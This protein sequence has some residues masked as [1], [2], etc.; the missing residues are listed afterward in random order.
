MKSKAFIVAVLVIGGSWLAVQLIQIHFR[1]RTMN[2]RHK[3]ISFT[4]NEIEKIK[5]SINKNIDESISKK[6]L[7]N[8]IEIDRLEGM[9][10]K[11]RMENAIDLSKSKENI[12][13]EFITLILL[14]VIS[15]QIG[16][17]DKKFQ[18]GNKSI[19]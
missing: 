18:A 15:M 19:E 8:V 10:R 9:I 4:R 12:F 5:K 16:M 17:I 7:L 6:D 14:V 3:E 2:I 1:R 13:P 11:I